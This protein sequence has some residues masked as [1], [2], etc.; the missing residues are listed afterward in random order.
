MPIGRQIHLHVDVGALRA[1]VVEF[2]GAE[3]GLQL[4]DIVERAAQRGAHAESVFDAVFAFE[5]IHAVLEIL[6]HGFVRR[7]AEGLRRIFGAPGG[8]PAARA[9]G[10]R[11]GRGE[12]ARMR[13]R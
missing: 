6:R 5:R 13:G 4:F 9:K 11:V 7:I 2:R 3:A 10:Q 12:F 8:A 1:R